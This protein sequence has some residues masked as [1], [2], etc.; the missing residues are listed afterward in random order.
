MQPEEAKKWRS[1]CPRG[2]SRTAAGGDTALG[3]SISKFVRLQLFLAPLS[4]YFCQTMFL[5]V[6]HVAWLAELPTAYLCA[7]AF[8]LIL[9]H[10]RCTVCVHPQSR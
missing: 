8:L 9:P 10:A 5:L 2:S 7:L 4:H 1:S 3:G 6:R